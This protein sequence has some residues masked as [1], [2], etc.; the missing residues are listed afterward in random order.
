MSVTFYLIKHQDTASVRNEYFD[1]SEPEDSIFNPRFIREEIYP[2]FNYANA[3]AAR[4][5]SI[6]GKWKEGEDLCGSVYTSKIKDFLEHVNSLE[7]KYKDDEY[8][9]RFLK[10]MDW[11]L[12]VAISLDDGIA[13]A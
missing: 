7:P 6:I 10:N 11:L 2:N 5:L 3:N 1:P 12:R 13:W 9:M 8:V 4:L